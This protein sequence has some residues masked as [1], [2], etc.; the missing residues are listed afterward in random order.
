MD[1]TA[2]FQS[3]SLICVLYIFFC[4]F[5][6]RDSFYEE[7]L[8][9][10]T[11]LVNGNNSASNSRNGS[12]SYFSFS[13]PSLANLTL[14]EN[15]GGTH[16]LC[17]DMF[18]YSKVDSQNTGILTPPLRLSFVV[19]SKFICVYLPRTNL[20]FL[21]VSLHEGGSMKAAVFACVHAQR[22]RPG[23]GIYFPASLPPSLP[24]SWK[25]LTSTSTTF[26]PSCLPRAFIRLFGSRR[27]RANG[28]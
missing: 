4:S 1:Q 19:Y 17:K 6:G 22:E 8:H 13:N 27:S 20:S 14:L 10:F 2:S 7:L 28:P 16:Q 24:P 21:L 3:D 23:L 15:V 9:N 18:I 26:I 11:V 25:A 5:Q 12:S